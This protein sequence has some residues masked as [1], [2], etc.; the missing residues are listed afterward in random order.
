MKPR[1]EV[2]AP[3]APVFK[4]DL[5]V[6]VMPG[7]ISLEM[8]GWQRI[9]NRVRRMMSRRSD[10]ECA[11][12]FLQNEPIF[13]VLAVDSVG[14][15]VGK[16]GV[17]LA[18]VRA[19]ADAGQVRGAVLAGRRRMMAPLGGDTSCVAAEV[20]DVEKKGVREFWR[21]RSVSPACFTTET[22]PR[23]RGAVGWLNLFLI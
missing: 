5:R 2:R 17:W 6:G 10:W 12:T 3:V 23:R 20:S 11:I 19:V 9:L 8:F 18:E 14:W 15:S 22:A 13:W 4:K 21:H 7:S 16:E 1:A